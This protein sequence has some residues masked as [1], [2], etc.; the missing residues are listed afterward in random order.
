MHLPEMRLSFAVVDEERAPLR[1]LRIVSWIEGATL[2]SLVGIAV[3]LKHLAGWPLGVSLLG[4]VHGLAFLT[5]LWM[6][7][8]AVSGGGWRPAEI[9]RLIG[10][11]LLPFGAFLNVGFIRRKELELASGGAAGAPP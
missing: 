10:A 1:N 5:Y 8:G 7:M 3:P 2:V 4:P 9:A 11:A 6:A